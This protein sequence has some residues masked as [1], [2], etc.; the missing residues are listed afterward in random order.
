MEDWSGTMLFS[1]LTGSLPTLLVWI[2]WGVSFWLYVL[3]LL[4]DELL[5]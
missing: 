5:V 2:A 3:L 1:G 4:D